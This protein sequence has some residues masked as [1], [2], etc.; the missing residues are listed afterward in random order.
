MSIYWKLSL[1]YLRGQM[2]HRG[3]FVMSV[4]RNLIS[5]LGDLMRLVLLGV[6]FG[7]MGHWTGAQIAVLYGII[8]VS[9]AVASALGAGLFSFSGLI[10]RG[11]FDRLL[12]RPCGT[13]TQVL[14]GKFDLTRLGRLTAGVMGL[15]WG[16]AHLDT[17]FGMPQA[18]MLVLCIFSG[19]LLFL[20][21]LM[22]QGGTC[23]WTIEGMEAFNAITYGGVAM[24]SYPLEVYKD[25]LRDLF[26]Y[27][28]PLGCL[29]YLPCAVL[30]GKS[31]PYPAFTAYLAPMAGG[32]YLLL[33]WCVWRAGLRHYRS[34]GA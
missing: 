22:I 17:T 31:L 6:S 28:I 30:F 15:I 3:S 25:E 5:S 13:M 27:V 29:N 20:G 1:A 19:V 14:G 2:Q 34:S 23:F 26:L 33:G 32:A 7:A 10:K 12:L 11:D 24:A 21:I 4:T 16:I 18:A 9:F 8:T